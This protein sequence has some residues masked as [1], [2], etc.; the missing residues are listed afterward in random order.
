MLT[1]FSGF[2]FATLFLLLLTIFLLHRD[3]FSI[4]GNNRMLDRNAITTKIVVGDLSSNNEAIQEL[5]LDN[6]KPPPAQLFDQPVCA[7]VWLRKTPNQPND[8]G[9]RIELITPTHQDVVT[10]RSDQV[11]SRRPRYCFNG[12]PASAL[13]QGPAYLKIGG[14]DAEPSKGLSLLVTTRLEADLP[15]RVG[16]NLTEFTLPYALDAQSGPGSRQILLSVLL[17]MFNSAIVALLLMACIPPRGTESR[18]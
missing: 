1:R 11:R 5:K 15:I 10:I 17:A 12:V 3:T 9:L 2:F 14:V 6:L 7:T 8:A 16:G 13:N 4:Y 18:S